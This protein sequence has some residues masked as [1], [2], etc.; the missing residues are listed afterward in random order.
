MPSAKQQAAGRIVVLRRFPADQK[1]IEQLILRDGDFRDM[2][3][4]LA[5]AEAAL[6]AAEKLP[7]TIR[8]ERM[9][10]WSASIERLSFEIARA[11]REA[12]LVRVGWS[13]YPKTRR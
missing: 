1:A 5:E 12:N 2:C 11:L 13:I 7:L 9:A 4:E 8:A 6:R 3:D 10:E